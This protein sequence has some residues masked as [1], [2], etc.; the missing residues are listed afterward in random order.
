MTTVFQSLGHGIRSMIMSLL[1]QLIFIVPLAYCF[2]K[3]KGLNAVWFAYPCAEFMVMIIFVPQA[4]KI[5]RKSF[6]AKS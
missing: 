1:R 2:A 5:I 6:A 4:L 3:V